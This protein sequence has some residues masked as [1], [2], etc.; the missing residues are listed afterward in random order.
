MSVLGARAMMLH[1]TSTMHGIWQGW[2]SVKLAFSA[3]HV[4]EHV[5][6]KLPLG[7]KTKAG[8]GGTVEE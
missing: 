8:T 3:N 7:A 5:S 4:D 6:A 1:S 2:H